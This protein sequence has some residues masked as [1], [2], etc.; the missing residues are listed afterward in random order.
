M[1]RPAHAEDG[2]APHGVRAHPDGEGARVPPRRPLHALVPLL[3]D[4]RAAYHL[5]VGEPDGHC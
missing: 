1:Y 4:G 5:T 3:P 2:P